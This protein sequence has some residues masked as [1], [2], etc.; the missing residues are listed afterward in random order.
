MTGGIVT[1]P[2]CAYPGFCPGEIGHVDPMGT[3]RVADGEMLVRASYENHWRKGGKPTTQVEPDFINNRE[4]R[5]AEGLSVWRRGRLPNP[6]KSTV[7]QHLAGLNALQ[8][9]VM[10]FEVSAAQLR[11][12][13]EQ[14]MGRVITILN[15][16]DTGHG[17]PRH[18]AHAAIYV[19][20]RVPNPSAALKY[21]KRSLIQDFRASPMV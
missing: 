18:D 3:P 19:C 2:A 4:L 17:N 16:T 21:V 13:A 7:E 1:A 6:A 12:L 11:G 15:Q 9:F 10:A 14:T 5:D 20:D 8:P